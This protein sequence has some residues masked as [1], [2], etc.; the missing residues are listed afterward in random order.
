MS[1]F[2]KAPT[3]TTASW[4]VCMILVV[5]LAG[6]DAGGAGNDEDGD[7]SRAALIGTWRLQRTAGETFLTSSTAQQV[8]DPDAPGEGQITL[9]GS[10]EGALTHLRRALPTAGKAAPVVASTGPVSDIGVLDPSTIDFRFAEG[11]S[12][13]AAFFEGEGACLYAG[14]GARYAY[15][16]TSGLTYDAATFTLSVDGVV[17]SEVDGG[18]TV[19][20]IGS[21]TAA[22]QTLPPGEATLVD[23]FSN[24]VGDLDPE[25]EGAVYVEFAEDGTF[26]AQAVGF[27]VTMGTWRL[28]DGALVVDSGEE[29]VFPAE[30]IAYQMSGG[31]LTFEDLENQYTFDVFDAADLPA[32][33]GAAY[34]AGAGTLTAAVQRN[35]LHFAP[36]NDE[37]PVAAAPA[38]SSAQN[39]LRQRGRPL[40]RF[41]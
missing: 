38:Q 31:Q 4:A 37:L 6:C 9:S 39:L 7:A 26:T 19:T 20:A 35:T 16:Q 41:Y 14:E 17:L 15:D 36:T 5:G 11:G 25:T 22:A 28:D 18:G 30:R 3:R 23:D 13:C 21:L 2:V 40:L 29:R 34:G 8:I 10:V 12:A 33:Y 1:S 24:F 32:R 27:Y